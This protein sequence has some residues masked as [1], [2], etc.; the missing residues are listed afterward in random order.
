MP[1]PNNALRKPN[2]ASGV[3]TGLPTVVLLLAI[4]RTVFSQLLWRQVEEGDEA[5]ACPLVVAVLMGGSGG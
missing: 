1:F 5:S 4:V 3:V 2:K